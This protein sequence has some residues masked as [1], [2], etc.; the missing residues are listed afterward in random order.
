[1]DR[2]GYY[3]QTTGGFYVKSWDSQG[4]FINDAQGKVIGLGKFKPNGSIVLITQRIDEEGDLIQGAKPYHVDQDSMISQKDNSSKMQSKYIYKLPQSIPDGWKVEDLRK[5]KADLEKIT[6]GVDKILKGTLPDINS[7]LILQHGKL[8]LDEYF[9]GHGV[10]D[11][12]LLYSETESVFSTVFGI[13]QDQGL[14]NVNQRIYD[15]YPENRSVAGWDSRKNS[16]T[17]GSLLAMIS[18]YDCNDISIGNGPTCGYQMT[19][20]TDW[21][22]Y[23]LSLPL[24]HPP[25]G[26]WNYNGSCLTLLSNLIA[27]KSGLSFQ[28]FSD[29]YFFKVLGISGSHWKMGPHE[30]A[31]VDEG[32]SWKPRDMAKL[33]LLYLN[34]GKWEGKRVVSQ[35]WIEEATTIKAPKGQAFGHDYGYLWHL[36]TMELNGVDAPVFFATGYLGQYIFVVPS[37]DLVCV[38]TADSNAPDIYGMEDA[39]FEQTILASF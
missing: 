36:K 1:L 4:T 6:L 37:E 29:K 20:T 30:V 13:A 38:I 2:V 18:G 21:T 23:C 31:K 3:P 28:D 27:H 10:E 35:K 39:F 26:T 15:L 22:T 14:L 16:I 5:V 32:L 25:G 11:E 33:G 7:L 19:Q 24:V 8:L 34:K 9:K 12:H 17:V